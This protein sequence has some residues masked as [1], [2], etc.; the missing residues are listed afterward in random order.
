MES[1]EASRM[2][3]AAVYFCIQAFNY[4]SVALYTRVVAQ[5][6]YVLACSMDAV[7]AL[8]NYFVIRRIATSDQNI[9]GLV[10]Y[11]AGSVCGTLLGIWSSVKLIGH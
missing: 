3:N 5:A 10:G 2:K 1:L 11:V 4:A 8:V 6:N 9:I 7:Y